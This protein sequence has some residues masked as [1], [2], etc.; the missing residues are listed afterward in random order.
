MHIYVCVYV[1]VYIYIYIYIF[2][3]LFMYFTLIHL[4]H[5]FDKRSIDLTSLPTSEAQ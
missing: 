2:G 4:K 3:F 5:N 1:C